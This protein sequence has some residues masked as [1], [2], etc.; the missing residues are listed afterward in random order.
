MVET[1]ELLG[2]KYSDSPVIPKLAQL[3]SAMV[4]RRNAIRRQADAG[5]DAEKGVAVLRSLRRQLNQWNIGADFQTFAPGLRVTYRRGRRAAERARK[6][7]N[8][9][10]LHELR[11]RVKDYWYQ[12]RLLESMWPAD[13][14]PE[15]ALRELQ[16]QLGDAHNLAVLRERPEAAMD[17]IVELIDELEKDLCDK[18]LAAADKLYAEKSRAHVQKL[19]ELWRAWREPERKSA[20][21]ATATTATAR[22]TSAA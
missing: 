22:A 18:A 8:A 2:K 4:R 17:G 1:V 6:K 16:E 3:R 19:E 20:R 11:K 9:R 14:C 7:P 21:T 5:T 13:E 10:N 15:T 12:V